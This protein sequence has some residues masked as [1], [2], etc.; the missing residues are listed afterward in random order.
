MKRFKL[1]LLCY[2]ASNIAVETLTLLY[3]PICI[4][5]LM[6][7]YSRGL[8]GPINITVSKILNCGIL[9]SGLSLMT[10]FLIMTIERYSA[11]AMVGVMIIPKW[12]TKPKSWIHFCISSL[13]FGSI[14]VFVI[15]VYNDQKLLSK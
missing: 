4:P 6:I 13:L 7:F 10:F 12:Y 2:T 14:S 3:E 1:Y 5:Y 9:V 8:L 15:K 11:M